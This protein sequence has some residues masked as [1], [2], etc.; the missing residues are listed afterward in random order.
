VPHESKGRRVLA[1]LVAVLAAAS[2]FVAPVSRAETSTAVQCTGAACSPLTTEQDVAP[3]AVPTA[4][5]KATCGVGD[6]VEAQ[7]GE[8][9]S[10]TQ[11]FVCNLREVAHVGPGSTLALAMYGHC[12]YYQLGF[13]KGTAVVD[14]ADAAH[15]KV[16]A[17]LT[18]P[19][20]QY[21]HEGLRVST[22]R[23]LLG[24][25]GA[26][27]AG[28]GYEDPFFD[29]YDVATDCAHPR[30]L[31]STLLPGLAGHEGTFAADGNTFYATEVNGVGL[32]AALDISDPSTAKV[33]WTATGYAAH[34]LTTSPD[35]NRLY[36]ATL[37]PKVPTTSPVP[38]ALGACNGV[39]ILDVSA[40]QA[41]RP[42]PSSEVIDYFCY[43][44]G[45]A[46]QVPFWFSSRGKPYLVVT[47]ES[48]GLSAGGVDVT[49]KGTGGHAR[50]ID[51]ADERHPRIVS[52]LITE[53]ELA[54]GGQN[55]HYCTPDRQVDPTVIGCTTWMGA[56]GFRV[57][58]VRDARRPRELAYFSVPSNS[59]GSP[60]YF[61]PAT[62]EAVYADQ[63]YGLTIVRFADRT[64]P[65]GGGRPKRPPLPL[66]DYPAAGTPVALGVTARAGQQVR[67]L[68][69]IR[70]LG[71]A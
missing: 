50:I 48:G 62:G 21:A 19:G 5:P 39:L 64:W 63:T 14:I 15:P 8:P 4:T 23:G 35:G 40:I 17:T 18:T 60:S 53:N 49:G 70:P 66:R 2:A 33:L 52:Q 29:A 69:G 58:D 3:Y 42:S 31:G 12:A 46:A 27:D 24:A 11:G 56:G 16:T 45:T 10:G 51:I 54:N 32:I 68:C 38:Q 37:N 61:L 22:T 59:S 47:D 55:F 41:R 26:G 7:Q 1:A 6:L 57:F 30:L 44:D 13:G 67:F 65:F 9:A 36:I 20:M 25:M 28:E 43:Q 71:A 34:G